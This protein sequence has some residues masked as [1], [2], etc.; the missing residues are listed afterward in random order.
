M[1]RNNYYSSKEEYDRRNPYVVIERVVG[2]N[3]HQWGFCNKKTADK[4]N[5]NELKNNGEVMTRKKWYKFIKESKFE[6]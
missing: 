2:G 4:F 3:Y 1:K 5:E 6:N